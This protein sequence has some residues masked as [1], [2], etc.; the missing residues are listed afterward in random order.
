MFLDASAMVAF[1]TDEPDRMH[2]QR[3]MYDAENPLVSAMAAYEATLAVARI[4]RNSVAEV[5]IDIS[6]FFSVLRAKVIPITEE[7]GIAALDA[8]ETYGNGRHRASLNMGDCFAY[9]CAKIHGVPLL[10]KGDDFIHTDI[11]IA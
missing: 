7:I 10:C 11:K 4:R 8:F 5:R 2:F 6:E 9:A 3:K 1:L